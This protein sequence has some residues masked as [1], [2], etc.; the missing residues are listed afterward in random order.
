MGGFDE[1]QRQQPVQRQDASRNGRQ[2]SR[3]QQ[4]DAAQEDERRDHGRRDAGRHG[5]EAA[6][7]PPHRPAPAATLL[8]GD[9]DPG[10]DERQH[11]I[12]QAIGDQRGDQ[13]RPRGAGQGG[14]HHGLEDA[15]AARHMRDQHGDDGERIAHEEGGPGGQRH[16]RHQH[17]QGCAGGGEIERGH[18]DL[19]Q[20]EPIAGDG[21]L[22]AQ[23]P[24]LPAVAT[25]PEDE[26]GERG[27]HGDADRA[28]QR[29]RQVQRAEDDPVRAER[30]HRAR[31][32]E[33]AAPEGEAGN[34][35]HPGDVADRQPFGA[36]DAIAGR[37]PG[38]QREAQIVAERVAGEGGERRN[39]IRQGAADR[40]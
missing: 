36:V 8:R 3:D 37:S 1:G 40:L 33:D 11:I 18:G 38:Q 24:Q 19:S 5:V 17:E 25:G 26:G 6:Q 22:P 29:R 15:D 35:D 30:Q 20:R 2:R 4:H 14:H 39:A 21:Q 10:D 31:Q 23:Q 28:P 16:V 12:E 13:L 7:R 32:R 9:D 34:G 27:Q